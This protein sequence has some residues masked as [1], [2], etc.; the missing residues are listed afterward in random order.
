MADF[1]CFVITRNTYP[2]LGEQ[3]I[4]LKEK[5]RKLLR[6][7]LF[8]PHF[9]ALMRTLSATTSL[10]MVQNSESEELYIVRKYG[11]RSGHYFIRLKVTFYMYSHL[12]LCKHIHEILP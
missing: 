7:G 6:M 9:I 12:I 2:R 4:I 3:T 11:I 5:M 1:A 10:H 8:V